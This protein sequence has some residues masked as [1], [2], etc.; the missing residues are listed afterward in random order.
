MPAP[1]DVGTMLIASLALEDP[2]FRRTVVLVTKYSAAEGTLGLVIN[3]PLG[4][5]VRLHLSDDL[6][7]LAGASEL[8]SDA[9]AKL[10]NLFFQGGPVE[11]EYVFI[12]HGLQEPIEGST[13]VCPG[14]YF[15]GDLEALQPR[16][17]V[18]PS[19]EPAVRFYLG[20]S[21][22]KEGQLESEIDMGAWVLAEGSAELVFSAQPDQAWQRALYSLGG[23][24]R[25]LSLIPEDPTVN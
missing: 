4:H 16:L 5:R 18:L 17:A 7:K 12:L 21:G 8:A 13:P 11:P 24:Y 20:Y 14:V 10:G 15:G 19:G 25:V 1:L 22:W 23:K 9:S 2:N 6:R 3:R